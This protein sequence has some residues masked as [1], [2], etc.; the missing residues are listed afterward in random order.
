[1]SNVIY[2]ENSISVG[3][4][5]YRFVKIMCRLKLISD[6]S[7]DKIWVDFDPRVHLAK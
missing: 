6:E 7:G 4:S 3:S 2:T 5:V 1:M